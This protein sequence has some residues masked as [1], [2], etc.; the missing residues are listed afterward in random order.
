MKS[1]W[2]GLVQKNALDLENVCMLVI[3]FNAEYH[4]HCKKNY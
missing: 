3:Q 2:L 1:S 4:K